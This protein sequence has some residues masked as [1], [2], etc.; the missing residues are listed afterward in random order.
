M[1][2]E[3]NTLELTFCAE[4]I[5]MLLLEPPSLPHLS[6]SD[7]PNPDYCDDYH[8]DYHYNDDYHDYLDYCDDY[9][10]YQDFHDDYHNA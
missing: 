5:I 2:R 4:F 3:F 9:H 1:F 10:D 8:D 7:L 6:T